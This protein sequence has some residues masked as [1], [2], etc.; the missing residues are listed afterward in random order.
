MNLRI[1]LS[2]RFENWVVSRHVPQPPPVSIRR[3][4]CYILPTRAGYMFAL[5][6]LAMLLGAMNYNNNLAFALTFLLAAT[7]LVAMHHP[8]ANL[9]G[10]TV[11]VGHIPAV[12]AGEPVWVPLQYTN[13]GSAD[14]FSLLAGLKRSRLSLDLAVD[15]ASGETAQSRFELPA[16]ERG[17]YRLPRFAVATEFPLGLFQSWSWL[18]LTSE[19]LVYPRPA[20]G[21][22]PIPPVASQHGTRSGQQ[23][24]RDDFSHLR[25]Y[26]PGD[27]LRSIHWKSFPHSGRLAVKTFAEPM[28]EALWL[29]WHQL[30]DLHDPE[31]RLSQLCRWILDCEAGQKPY[32]LRLPGV[33][34]APARGHAHRTDCLERLARLK[35]GS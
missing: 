4:R 12:F 17:V 33:E 13:A 9:L 14:R 10:L 20:T 34:I 16:R 29:D 19:Y 31:A 27:A 35:V 26:R 6:L 18:S 2:E 5:M 15:C 32:G 25:D 3:G 30:T 7:S 21:Q 28:D 11:H 24:G 1:R 22:R 8:H 23:E